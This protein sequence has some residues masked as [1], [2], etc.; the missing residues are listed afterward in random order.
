MRDGRCRCEVEA[1]GAGL[2]LPVRDGRCQ[3][4]AET[5][6]AGLTLPMWS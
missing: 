6:G 5:A 2:R 3:C 1:A 4:E